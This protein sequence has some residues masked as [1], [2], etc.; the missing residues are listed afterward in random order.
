MCTFTFVSNPH[1]PPPINEIMYFIWLFGAFLVTLQLFAAQLSEGEAAQS[2]A[3]SFR[4]CYALHPSLLYFCM[5]RCLRCHSNWRPWRV[6]EGLSGCGGARAHP[7]AMA[8]PAEWQWDVVAAGPGVLCVPA[9]LSAP[10]C[11]STFLLTLSRGSATT[12]PPRKWP[13]C[14]TLPCQPAP[15]AVL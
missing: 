10:H 9:S 11:P 8:I 6:C 12:S 15:A 1:P 3:T 7:V 13:S 14:A 5:S 4:L 2:P